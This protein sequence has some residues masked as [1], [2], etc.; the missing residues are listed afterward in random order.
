LIKRVIKNKATAGQISRIRAVLRSPGERAKEMLRT[1]FGKKIASN[2][3]SILAPDSDESMAHLLDSLRVS[4]QMRFY[5][6]HPIRLLVSKCWTAWRL[7]LR[8]INPSGLFIVL[9]GPTGAGKSTMSHF[10]QQRMKRGFREVMHFRSRQSLPSKRRRENPL[11]SSSAIA[12]SAADKSSMSYV[13]FFHYW[14]DFV[15]SY[16]LKIYPAK[17]RSTLIMGECNFIDV[18]VDPARYGILVPL[19]LMR[20]VSAFVPKPDLTVLLEAPVEELHARRPELSREELHTQLHKMRAALPNTGCCISTSES[21]DRAADELTQAVLNAAQNHTAFLRGVT[22]ERRHEWRAFPKADDAK[23]WIHARDRMANALNLYHPYSWIGRMVIRVVTYLP[24]RLT[25]QPMRHADMLMLRRFASA[26]QRMLGSDNVIVSFFTG[27]QSAHRKITAQVTREGV[28]IAYVKIGSSDAAKKLVEA[29]IAALSRLD[30][31]AFPKDISAPRV[32]ARAMMD[33]NLLLALSA[34]SLPGKP[35]SIV[36]DERDIRFLASLVPFRPRMEP[37]RNILNAIGFGGEGG[38]TYPEFLDHACKSVGALL[39]HGVRM[40][41]MHGDYVP[42][43][44][45]VLKDGSLFVFDWEHAV[46]APL[47]SDFF[48]RVFLPAR[49]VNGGISP[50]A[51]TSRLLDLMNLPLARP[52]MEKMG[53]ESAEFPAYLLLYFLQ[54]AGREMHEKGGI[55]EYLQ[56]CVRLTLIFMGYPAGPQARV[57]VE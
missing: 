16:W 15:T 8:L 22:I 10:L 30:P 23:L 5:I 26:I 50:Q 38:T 54:L 48:H 51:A 6:R 55:D 34:P 3:D 29:E 42:W 1:Y 17:A 45:L 24:R 21:I 12:Y 32:L 43:N 18:M 19:W 20:T 49:L 44:T 52:L 53:I 14:L 4:L 40:G 13:R 25:T 27:T 36:L 31:A 7:A 41:P 2:I 46:E 9:I 56:E 33:D 57:A 11:P 37:L 28:I 35:H 47:L 39:G